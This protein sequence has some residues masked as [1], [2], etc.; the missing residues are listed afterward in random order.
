MCLPLLN[1][2]AFHDVKPRSG[3]TKKKFLDVCEEASELLELRLQKRLRA[4]TLLIER[5]R[6]MSAQV[7]A[8]PPMFDK[9]NYFD[10]I[11]G[12]ETVTTDTVH[13]VKNRSRQEWEDSVLTRT[14]KRLRT[15]RPTDTSHC[16]PSL[17][18][19]TKCPLPP[20]KEKFADATYAVDTS[21]VKRAKRT[22]KKA[23]LISSTPAHQEITTF[24][25]PS[26]TRVTRTRKAAVARQK[27][28][29]LKP[30]DV[31]MSSNGSPILNPFAVGND[32]PR[33]NPT[34]LQH[35]RKLYLN[36]QAFFNTHK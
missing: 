7:A 30:D 8:L 11:S 32:Q 15:T 14:R 1:S 26:T 18:E 16:E 12:K 21:T 36:L 34:D 3:W 25:I 20:I 9:I 23:V 13:D 22:S 28:R 31:L 4:N 5:L 17:P 6:S 27:M 35:T 33:L 19:E 10:F 2:F 29:P 24:A